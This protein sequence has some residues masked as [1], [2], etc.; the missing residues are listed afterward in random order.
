[1]SEPVRIAPGSF[2]AA[3]ATGADQRARAVLARLGFAPPRNAER[4]LTLQSTDGP[5]VLR[6]L[7]GEAARLLERAGYRVEVDPELRLSPA[8][9]QA[10]EV[11]AE[12]AAR[13]GEL[14]ALVDS[15]DDVRDLADVGAQMVTGPYSTRDA[16]HALFTA[17][18]RASLRA[19]G[20]L[21]E[22]AD[23]QAWHMDGAAAARAIATAAAATGYPAPAVTGPR[24]HAARTRSPAARASTARPV[25]PAAPS[26][27]APGPRRTR[28]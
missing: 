20:S 15:M 26:E 25:T 21:H 17:G 27:P 13:L 7:V 5:L 18:A 28:A 4:P 2:G 24:V 11:L 1:M 8:G 12:I 9:E 23:L 14:T 3:E 19:D 6:A 16:L 22:R 10:L